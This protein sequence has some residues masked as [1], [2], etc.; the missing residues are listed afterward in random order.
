M[1]GR[2]EL[3]A[4]G[5]L[6]DDVTCVHVPQQ[7][8]R[9]SEH[10]NKCTEREAVGRASGSCGYRFPPSPLARMF[11][12]FGRAETPETPLTFRRSRSPLRV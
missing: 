1:D 7:R 11:T 2:V 10:E 3:A 5:P 9:C 8:H 12:H 6:G 4:W